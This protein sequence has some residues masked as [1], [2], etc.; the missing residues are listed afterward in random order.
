MENEKV[1]WTSEFETL[2]YGEYHGLPQAEVRARQHPR[3]VDNDTG[4]DGSQLERCLYP[5]SISRLSAEEITV[6]IAASFS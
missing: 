4:G 5:R 6:R 1:G 2:I 3:N